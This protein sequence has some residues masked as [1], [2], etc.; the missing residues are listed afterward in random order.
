V[1]GHAW[2]DGVRIMFAWRGQPALAETITGPH[3][4]YPG[5]QAGYYSFPLF[6]DGQTPCAGQWDIWAEADGLTSARVPFATTGPGQG[7]NQ[8]EVA[9]ALATS[10]ALPE[11]EPI[12]AVGKLADKVRW[13]MEESIRQDEAGNSAR[14]KAI[15]YSLIKLA[16]GLLYRLENALKAGHG[17][18]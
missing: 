15:R 16:G 14:A 1:F 10:E 2:R 3:T 6:V 11:S 4:G 12:M 5:W 18:G 7:I 8:V 9:F 17:Q 13:W